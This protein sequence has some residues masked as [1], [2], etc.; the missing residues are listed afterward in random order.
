MGEP[1]AGGG[2]VKAARLLAPTTLLASALVVL[3]PDAWL[4]LATGLAVS[5]CLGVAIWAF[6]QETRR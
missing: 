3:A 1:G 6:W 5:G 2:A 4:P